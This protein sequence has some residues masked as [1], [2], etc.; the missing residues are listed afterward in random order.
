MRDRTK[1]GVSEP[2]LADRLFKIVYRGGSGGV[3]LGSLFE[4]SGCPVSSELISDGTA[5]L[6]NPP[7]LEMKILQLTLSELTVVLVYVLRRW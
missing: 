7:E 6:D 3:I 5:S 1:T 2:H 4:C